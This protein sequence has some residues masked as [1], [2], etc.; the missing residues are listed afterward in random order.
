MSVSTS[1]LSGE[2]ADSAPEL[3]STEPL[4]KMTFGLIEDRTGRIVVRRRDL[5]SLRPVPDS[6][7]EW[8]DL[9]PGTPALTMTNQY[10]DQYGTTTEY[11]TDFLGAGRMLSAEQDVA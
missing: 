5:V 10:W 2:L 6:L 9:E 8:L 7:A 4:P 3:I 1:W 11:A